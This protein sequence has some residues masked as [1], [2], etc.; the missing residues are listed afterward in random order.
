MVAAEQENNSILI[1]DDDLRYCKILQ[2]LLES[3]GYVVHYETSGAGGIDALSEHNPDLVILDVILDEDKRG[4][5]TG[6]DICKK[7]YG[8]PE[9][10]Q[11][12]VS[13][14]V[15]SA[16]YNA[17]HDALK[18][19][20]YFV[21]REPDPSILLA[22]IK[23]LFEDRCRFDV[24]SEHVKFSDDL[25]IKNNRVHCVGKLLDRPAGDSKDMDVLKYM[26]RSRIMGIPRRK[27]EI[28][29][30]VWGDANVGTSAATA[31]ITRV[32]QHLCG[33]FRIERHLDQNIYQLSAPGERFGKP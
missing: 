29:K 25:Y 1:V 10:K 19:G 7:I 28:L 9:Y 26:I 4:S 12:S 11:G 17:S 30:D 6:I 21:A 18:H 22:T 5:I 32:N 3:E 14:I 27:K 31:A 16:K 15:I 2:T 33:S 24:H 20:A 13:I 23:R 8:S